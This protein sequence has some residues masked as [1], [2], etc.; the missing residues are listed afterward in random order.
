MTCD[1]AR[2]RLSARL[3]DALGPDERNALDAHVASCVDC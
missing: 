1:E 2:E 3:D